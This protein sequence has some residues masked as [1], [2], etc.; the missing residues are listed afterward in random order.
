VRKIGLKGLGLLFAGVYALNACHY[1][2]HPSTRT[3]LDDVVAWLSAATFLV[4]YGYGYKLLRGQSAVPARSVLLP[5]IPLVAVCFAT[6]PYDS[7]DVYLYMDIGW[8]QTH[9]G[10]NPYTQILREIPGIEKDPM[11]RSEWMQSNKNPWLDLPLVYGFGFA[12]L[13]KLLAWSGRGYWWVTLA[14]FKA[15]NVAAYAVCCRILW[16]LS[17]ALGN[18]RP[19]LTVYLFAWSPLVLQ[20]H[21]AN[22]HN[23]LLVGALV[24]VAA[25]QLTSQRQAIF[26]PAALGA[27][28]LIK[29]VTLPLIPVS[30]WLVAK[31][32]GMR[33]AVTAAIVCCVV[34]L[35]PGIPY[36]N[37]WHAFRLDLISAQL[38]KITAGSFYSFLF[39]LYRAVSQAVSI[40][41]PMK[42]FGFLLKILLWSIGCFIVA[43]EAYRFFR[44]REP[45]LD[46]WIATSSRIL[47]AII[48]IISSQFYSWYI[49][50][51]LPLTLMLPSEDRLKS[52]SVTLS[53][54][55]VFSLT[56]LSRKGIGYFVLTL[57][58]AIIRP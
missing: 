45:S 2:W 39:Y 4:L 32:R 26:A 31:Q 35:I 9:D 40:P 42:T 19:D 16:L 10:M 23:D 33:Q 8:A 29:Y 57:L 3:T 15:V 43:A 48:F 34:M 51:F 50:M 41:I 18:L 22:A 5:A 17:K 1:G 49:G 24:A 13:T 47:F 11:I 7:T 12:L 27:A 53:G 21:I 38:N 28:A 58:P 25:Y 36:L 54:T 14:L 52:F 55:H 20:H 46:D 56:S 6:M 30:L 37:A 44:K